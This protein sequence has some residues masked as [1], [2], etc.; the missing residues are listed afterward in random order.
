MM[1][2]DTFNQLGRLS[3]PWF[4]T[5]AGEG[6]WQVPVNLRREK[7]RY[8][9]EADLPGVDRDSIDVSVDGGWLTIRAERSAE[10]ENRDARWLVRERSSQ[11][12]VRRLALGQ[13]VDVDAIAANYD[14]GVLRIELPILAGAQPRRI[15]V[16]AGSG[17]HAVGAA[18]QDAQDGEVAP[19]K[20][21][22]A[23]SLAS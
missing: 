17:Q 3:D 18:S 19:G 21:Q 22:P 9:L 4:S 15:A 10:S 20:A 2:F 13:D 8:L 14:D 16:A 11:T 7:D 6:A 12:V 23:R 1:L 5:S